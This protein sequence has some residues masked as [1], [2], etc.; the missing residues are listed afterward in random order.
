MRL[1][2][3]ASGRLVLLA[4]IGVVPPMPAELDVLVVE[5]HGPDFDALL[6]AMAEIGAGARL[7][8]AVDCGAAVA[9]CEHAKPDALVIDL[10][11]PDGPGD[12][13][14]AH[15]KAKEG[16]RDVPALV[17]SGRLDERRPIA[18]ADAVLRKGRTWA[19]TVEVATSLSERLRALAPAATRKPSIVV[20]DD[21]P[22]DVAL[23]EEASREVGFAATFTLLGGRD[24]F[25]A[26]LR[27][28]TEVPALVLLDINL[29]GIDGHELIARLKASPRHAEVPVVMYSSSER[30]VDR[31]RGVTLGA[32]GFMGKPSTFDGYLPLARALRDVIDWRRTA[33]GARRPS[34]SGQAAGDRPAVAKAAA[35]R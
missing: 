17:L 1:C 31:D 28:G 26:W 6:E 34:I 18:H 20:V 14:L 9:A 15:L 32:L 21:N 10:G 3:L 5:D 22:C 19:E 30:P 29:P 11:L 7:R 12:E 2:N 33:G 13:L 27:G 24:A 23:L 25:E 8:R 16:M 4:V 35:A